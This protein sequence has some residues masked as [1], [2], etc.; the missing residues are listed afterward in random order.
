MVQVWA[1]GLQNAVP[2]KKRVFGNYSR[3]AL[4]A[5]YPNPAPTSE[6]LKKIVDDLIRQLGEND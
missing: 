3:A 1:V 5:L 2:R 4:Q 6:V